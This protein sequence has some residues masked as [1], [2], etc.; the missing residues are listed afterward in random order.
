MRAPFVVLVL[1]LAIAAPA[2]GQDTRGSIQGVISDS[3]GAAMPGVTVEARSS[4][5][6]GIATAITDE[7]GTYRFPALPPGV[8]EV[9]AAL[10][11][12]TTATS[13]TPR[14]SNES[15]RDATSRI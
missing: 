11:G 2:F 5:L 8:Y 6:V 12:F 15:R 3:S 13:A 10:Q 4:A 1:A 9:T 14:W 7:R